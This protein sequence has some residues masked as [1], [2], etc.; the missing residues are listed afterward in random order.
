MLLRIIDLGIEGCSESKIDIVLEFDG[1]RRNFS[2]DGFTSP[3]TENFRKALDWYYTD[4]PGMA[5]F[6]N[7]DR[8]VSEKIITNGG[9]AGDEILGEDFQLLE[10]MQVI[11]QRGWS[12]LQVR[13]E[14]AGTVFF[15]EMWESLILHESRY[16]LSTQVQS[17][18]RKCIFPGHDRDYPELRYGLAVDNTSN[19]GAAALL[20][21]GGCVETDTVEQ[22]E[23]RSH[24]PLR[25]LYVVSRP[26]DIQVE[27]GGSNAIAAAI[28]AK[29]SGGAIDYEVHCLVDRDALLA[30]IAD[31]EFPI[32][33]LHYDGPVMLGKGGVALPVQSAVSNESWIQVAELARVLCENNVALMNVDA[34]TYLEDGSRTLAQKG[35]AM[36][37]REAQSAGLGN[38]VGL[39]NVGH[40]W[41]S[42]TCFLELYR[43]LAAG[44]ELG[45]AVVEARKA[46]QSS[47][48]CTTTSVKPFSLHLWPLL[49]HYSQQEVYFFDSPQ[50]LSPPIEGA[51]V[52][53]LSDKLF[54]FEPT[55]LPPVVHHCSDGP[56][57]NL[58]TADLEGKAAAV[59]GSPGSGKSLIAHLY[60]AFQVLKGEID[61]AFRF[62]YRDD[63]FSAGDIQSML[64][65]ILEVQKGEND[66]LRK[67]LAHLRCCFVID[68]LTFTSTFGRSQSDLEDL[69]VLLQD[70]LSQGHTLLLIGEESGIFH[71]LAVLEVTVP[72]LSSIE[73]TILASNELR[74]LDLKD[75]RLEEISG[76]ESW[77]SFLS[78]LGGN[79]WMIKKAVPLLESMSATELTEELRR[80]VAPVEAGSAL[81]RFYEWQWSLLEPC[82]QR[83]LLFCSGTKNLLLEMLVVAS[84]QQN[85]FDLARKF[86]TL[87]GGEGVRISDGLT[88]ITQAGFISSMPHGR[89]VD[90]RCLGFLESMRD[91]CLSGVDAENAEVYFSKIVCEGI[92]ILS[93]HVVHSP[94][95]SITNNL[96]LNRR[97]WVRHFESLWFSGDYRGFMQAKNAFEQLLQQL[98]L[99]AEIKHWYLDL[100]DR[101]PL[102]MVSMEDEEYSI[103]WLAIGTSCLGLEGAKSASVDKA[104]DFW[105]AWFAALP[106][107]VPEEKLRVFHQAVNFLQRYYQV[108]GR[109]MDA[110]GVSER[111]LHAYLRQAAWMK[112]AAALKS[113][114]K[115]HTL[116]N[117]PK[118]AKA[119]EDRFAEE[120]PAEK[121]PATYRFQ[122]LL[123]FL[124]ARVERGDMDAALYLL[125]QLRSQSKA[126]EM[127]DVLDGVE[128]DIRFKQGH[129]EDAL[130]YYCRTWS[131]L[132][133]ARHP[134]LSQNLE[135]LKQRLLEFEKAM[136]SD[137][138]QHC[139]DL[140]A[141]EGTI[142][143]KDYVS[144]LH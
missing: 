114:S 82:W 11:D 135:Q 117:Q 77:R 100:L 134:G 56:L 14:S 91:T 66:K 19:I 120:I 72:S 89:I 81:E 36:L 131:K 37:A 101:S 23:K 54:G 124:L 67:A 15:Q 121:L 50:A 53:V 30:R 142:Y 24:R 128:A 141:P 109:W 143:P 108:S 112:A 79:P 45:L 46:L 29:L 63:F 58:S 107:F 136:G 132:V 5:M 52:K 86:L 13:I 129:Y 61:Y 95:V 59:E 122:C 125:Y 83:L 127:D 139:F 40:S 51:F 137:A 49:V 98:Q 144:T 92:R 39:G 111:A 55:L 21:S 26:D 10:M 110:L 99:D 90:A 8:G 69:R 16:V 87:L 119:C 74:V 65:P 138:F 75:D 41:I 33:V 106:E 71:D 43:Q 42:E 93:Q 105:Q 88:I 7:D 78:A 4:Y 12:G 44:R 32:H 22:L 28:D 1:G 85:G 31:N 68:E 118:Q 64:S 96:V 6:C 3:Q 73:Q 2:V 35:L 9:Y 20:G 115:S 27:L 60:C 126:D 116:L 104:V 84:E 76:S 97:H 18:V 17:F 25:V 48:E 62:N 130:P 94:N 70:L 38:I 103:C 133:T 57:L 123:D 102:P 113:M 80:N 140:E 47:L 34:R